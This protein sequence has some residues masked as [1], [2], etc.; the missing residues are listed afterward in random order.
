MLIPVVLSGGSGTRLWPLSR[1]AYPKQFCDLLDESLMAKTLK[2]A[3]RL[4]SP[5]TLT[6]ESLALMTKRAHREAEV[7]EEQILLEPKGRNTAPAIAFLCRFLQLRGQGDATVA[8]F[9]ADHLISKQKEFER[10]IALAERCAREGWVVTLG[11]EPNYP[12]TGFGYIEIDRTES[13]RADGDLFARRARGFREKP[14]AATA[15]RFVASGD[16]F[17]N[18]G[19]FVFQADRMAEHFARLAP[20]TWRAFSEL[21]LDL[22]NLA[23]AYERAP[24]ASVDYAIMEK[25]SELACVPCDLGWSDLG[26]WDDVADVAAREGRSAIGG[27]ADAIEIDAKNS[28]VFSTANKLFA[29]VGLD[30]VTIVDTPDAMLAVRK[31]SA[32]RV[33]EA[34]EIAGKLRPGVEKFHQFERR[35]WGG[36]S[37]L[38]DEAHY[39]FK[40]IYVEP[41]A[42]ISYQSHAKRAEHW[43]V[44]RGRGEVTLEGEI[45]PVQ[46]GGSVRIPLGAKHRIR[47]VGAENLEF[48]EVQTGTYF[49]EDDIVRY[50][51]DYDRK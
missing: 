9:P 8:I 18:A 16:F 37:V 33:R 40:H 3:R 44:V 24:A 28:F 35:P 20:D 41:G 11:I 23:E 45:I 51:D 34:A 7:P 49:G 19:I 47:C 29:L 46:A 13:V 27:R 21:K 22:S 43:I 15:K 31:G 12:A 48:I 5:W 50:Q 38:R 26:S 6:T 30:D 36:F 25:L 4:G 32:Q 39:K 42:Q 2:R 17:W 14:D 1:A 10:A